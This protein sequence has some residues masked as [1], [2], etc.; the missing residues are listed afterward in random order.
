M[1]SYEGKY[2]TEDDKLYICIRDSIS[3]LYHNIA[4]LIGIYFNEVN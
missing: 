4:D 2:Y 1:I 3:A